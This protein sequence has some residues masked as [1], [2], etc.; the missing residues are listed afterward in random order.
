[1]KFLYPNDATSKWTG[2][3]RWVPRWFDAS[4]DFLA[5]PK[6]GTAVADET[7]NITAP[8]SSGFL[9]TEAESLSATGNYGFF[10]PIAYQLNY[11]KF[12]IK[13]LRST[14]FFSYS[15][16]LPSKAYLLQ[17]NKTTR[18][19]LVTT[20]GEVRLVQYFSLLEALLSG[21]TGWYAEGGTVLI[22][23]IGIRSTNTY[24]IN[25]F[26]YFDDEGWDKTKPLWIQHQNGRW[27]LYHPSEIGRDGLL[28]VINASAV[29]YYCNTNNFNITVKVNLSYQELEPFDL[30]DPT[31]ENLVIRNIP[32]LSQKIANQRLPYLWSYSKDQS[33]SSVSAGLGTSLG[34]FSSFSISDGDTF[35]TGAILKTEQ[36]ALDFDYPEDRYIM[37]TNVSDII[38]YTKYGEVPTSESGGRVNS[39]EIV[40][41][42][43]LFDRLQS[44]YQGRDDEYITSD[45]TINNNTTNET[46][47]RWSREERPYE[48][49]GSGNFQ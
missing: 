7:Y 35:P 31:D 36:Y 27:V 48:V 8:L 46:V 28:P 6:L 17:D 42:R 15:L 33:N 21:Q 9:S 10:E 24:T 2:F 37:R 43:S 22:F 30:T 38:G 41:T 44:P 13:Y 1:M 5:L 29:K 47:Y 40:Y 18:I 34:L 19:D 45:V 25:G 32:E 26:S 11:I 16:A 4:N 49:N 23:G 20:E 3:L 14:S 39:S 12:F